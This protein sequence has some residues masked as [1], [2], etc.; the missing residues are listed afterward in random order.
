M[1]LILSGQCLSDSK[2]LFLSHLQLTY[3]CSCLSFLVTG[4]GQGKL[5]NLF[6]KIEKKKLNIIFIDLEFGELA[7]PNPAD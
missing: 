5:K 7:R 3:I 4:A 2:H 1:Q 6:N